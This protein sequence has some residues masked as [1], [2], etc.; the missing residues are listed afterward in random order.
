MKAS[1]S[2]VNRSIASDTA[3][4]LILEKLA[5]AAGSWR[6]DMNFLIESIIE[7]EPGRAISSSS[8]NFDLNSSKPGINDAPLIAIPAAKLTE[9][10]V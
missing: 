9:L 7:E 5:F 8:L 10:L 4:K 2:P 3:I 1:T 6:T